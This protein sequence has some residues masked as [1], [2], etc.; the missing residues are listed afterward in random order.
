MAEQLDM[1][2]LSLHDSQHAPGGF[3]PERAAYIPPHLRRQQQSGPPPAMD[4]PAPAPMM[5]GAGVNGSAWGPDRGYGGPPPQQRMNNGGGNWANA[6]SFTPRGSDAPQ[7]RGNGSWNGAAPG[8]FDPNA[9]G[10]PGA[11]G[12]GSA[13]GSGDG[14]WRDGKHIPGP[15]N[16]RVERELFGVPNDPS[17]QHTGINFEKY[18]DIPV[19]ASGQGVPEPVTTFTNPPLDDH[20]ITNIELAGYKV[21]TDRK[22]VV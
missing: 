9:Y 3:Q 16:P 22:S 4:G 21:P 7:A 20:L 13:R 12:S 1:G 10:K 15:S 2:R 11:A 6:Q 19:E 17:K 18:D 5:N 8:K 14:Q